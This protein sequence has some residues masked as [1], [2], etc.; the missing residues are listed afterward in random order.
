MQHVGHVRPGW[1]Q[2][3]VVVRVMVRVDATELA[4]W[5]RG[6]QASIML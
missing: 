1:V 6:L 2:A 4:R 5:A 3:G